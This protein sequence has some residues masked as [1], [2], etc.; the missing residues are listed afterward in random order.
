MDPVSEALEL[1]R[2]AKLQ[3]KVPFWGSR[4]KLR[5]L[6]M[7]QFKKNVAEGQLQKEAASLGRIAGVQDPAYAEALV[8]RHGGLEGA[9]TAIPQDRVLR[10]LDRYVRSGYPPRGDRPVAFL[11]DVIR[12]SY[13]RYTETYHMR[14]RVADAL[15]EYIRLSKEYKNDL[16]M[17]TRR[18]DQLTYMLSTSMD[19]PRMELTPLVHEIVPRAF[20][21]PAFY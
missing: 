14:D 17:L 18:L 16:E 11:S 7:D 10:K 4:K 5:D 1:A 6:Q 12:E 8:R 13:P 2:Q 15:R 20:L 9:L 21:E 19:I 3:K